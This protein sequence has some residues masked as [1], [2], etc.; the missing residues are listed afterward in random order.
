MFT[1]L[2][3]VFN[4]LHIWQDTT[5]NEYRLTERSAHILGLC[6]IISEL[7]IKCTRGVYFGTK[8]PYN[9]TGLSRI[10]FI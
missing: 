2:N 6:I 10:K 3:D 8:L 1:T 9:I 7:Y 5:L 4:T